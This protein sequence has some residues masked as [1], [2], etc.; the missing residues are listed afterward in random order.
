MSVGE[1]KTKKDVTLN[2]PLNY[3]DKHQFSFID[4]FAGLGGFHLAM[5][6][7][8]GKCVF[9]SELKEDLRILYKENYGIDCFGDINKVDIDKDIPKKF[10]ML[11][12]GGFYGSYCFYFMVSTF[13]CCCK[14]S[15]Q[16][17]KK[18]WR[19][20]SNFLNFFSI[21][22]SFHIINPRR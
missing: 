10:D 14:W 1:R 19:L 11:C 21:N 4:L 16:Q 3:Q 22:W 6:K 9:A 17:R 15:K 12:A 20:F 18:F 2:A 5:Q 13:I 8:G 7:L